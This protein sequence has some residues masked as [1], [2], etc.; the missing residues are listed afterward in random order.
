MN[1]FFEDRSGG[2]WITTTGSGVALLS[3]SASNVTT[4]LTSEELPEIKN[5]FITS[6][7]E[8]QNSDLWIGSVDGLVIWDSTKNRFKHSDLTEHGV[9]DTRVTAIKRNLVQTWVGTVNGGL[10]LFENGE[11]VSNFVQ[12]LSNAESISD[13]SIVNI[14]VSSKDELWISHHRGWLSK[15]LGEGRFKKYSL[16]NETKEISGVLGMEIGEDAYGEIWVGTINN[17]VLILNPDSGE[18][19]KFRSGFGASSV[20]SLKVDGFDVWLGS[21]SGLFK[22]DVRSE[23]L[24]LKTPEYRGPIFAIEVVDGQIWFSTGVGVSVLEE[25]DVANFDYSHGLLSS[26]YST[27][28]SSQLS[29]GKIIFGGKK[30]FSV[31]DPSKIEKNDYRPNVVAIEVKVNGEKAKKE[32]LELLGFNHSS[33]SVKFA[34]LDYTYPEKNQYRY[35]LEGFDQ[36]WIDNGT[37]RDVTYTNLD[38]GEYTLRVMGSNSD[39]LW[40]D[41]QLVLPVV[42]Q[43]PPWATWWAYTLYT[44]IA[45]FFIVYVSH[46]ISQRQKRAA[47]ERYSRRLELYL[48]SLDEASDFVFNAGQDGRILFANSTSDSILE[49]SLGEVIGHPMLEVLFENEENAK[50]AQLELDEKGVHK[51]EVQTTEFGRAKNILEV[52]IS[53]SEQPEEDVAYVGMVRDVTE[54]S[55]ERRELISDN[56]K[57]KRELD[58]ISDRLKT[59]IGESLDA[60]RDLAR[61]A[62]EKEMLLRGIHDRV[63]DNFQMLTSLLNIQMS[64]SALPEVIQT[65]EDNQQRINALAMVHENLYDSQ[66]LRGVQM[67]SYINMLAT[68]I[69]RRFQAD[70]INIRFEQDVDGLVLDLS[71]AVPCGLIV[72]ELLSNALEHAFADKRRKPGR[73]SLAVTRSAQNCVLT[74]SDNGKGL[75]ADFSIEANKNMGMEIVSILTEQLGGG[76]RLIGGVGTTFE[77]SFPITSL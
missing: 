54:Q 10:M 61:S 75:P 17:G 13:N 74:V 66:E 48:V 16:E 71:Q 22:Y 72:N 69:Y 67:D 2:L 60:N 5:G 58:Q 23:K 63:S 51:S 53:R 9:R 27:L 3:E 41:K 28:S 68:G 25:S 36:D 62:N 49:K 15:Y 45:F 47:E 14:F 20:L 30:G 65:L 18:V 24:E 57:L 76:L 73:V 52:S 7:A 64:K 33:F 46:L 39:G 38:P 44:L 50:T 59:R 26:G 11:F 19:R 40:S 43:A 55:L 32:N 31:L 1:G 42:V 35:M 29:D 56:R 77:V 37:D 12:D 34:A 21:E 70:G 8:V 4:Y 6:F